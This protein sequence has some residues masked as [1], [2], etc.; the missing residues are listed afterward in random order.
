MFKTNITDEEFIK[1]VS[2]SKSIKEIIEKLG[3]KSIGGNY[4][5]V[6]KRIKKLGLNFVTSGS[7]RDHTSKKRNKVTDEQFL[8][9]IAENISMRATLIHLDIL[10]EASKKNRGVPRATRLWFQKKADKLNPDLSHWLGQGHLKD[11]SHDWGVGSSLDL[12]LVENSNHY[13]TSSLKSKIFEAELLENKCAVCSCQPIWN[14]KPISL[15][16]DH[17]NGIFN[18]NRIENLRILCPN[19]HSQTSTYTGKNK[20]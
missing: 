4:E 19:C 20:K 14:Y 18:D 16:L 5:T 13:K 8:N 7:L 6:I 2:E 10:S 3:Y 12:I 15:Q 11:K 1:A 17:I 9:A